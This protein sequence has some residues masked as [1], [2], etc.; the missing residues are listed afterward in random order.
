[1]ILMLAL[2]CSCFGFAFQ[3]VAQKYLPAETAAVFTVMNPLTASVMGVVIAHE[4]LDLFVLIGYVL[5]LIALLHFNLSNR[6]D[7]SVP[8]KV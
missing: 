7:G 1:M 8:D 6:E 2:V 3:P 4:K 5:I